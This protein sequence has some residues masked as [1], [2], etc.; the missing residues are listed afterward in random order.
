MTCVIWSST[1]GSSCLEIW[2]CGAGL[3]FPDVWKALCSIET[4]TN[5]GATQSSK[6]KALHSFETSRNANPATQPYI[7]KDLEFEWQMLWKSFIQRAEC[8]CSYR[9]L[10]VSIFWQGSRSAMKI[11][12][13]RCQLKARQVWTCGTNEATRIAQYPDWCCPHSW[14]FTV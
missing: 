3:V 14:D 8:I 12:L 9:P 7:S 11:L 13:Y 1:W 10:S 6:L 2:R 5:A 4:S